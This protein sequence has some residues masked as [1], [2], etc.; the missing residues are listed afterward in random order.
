MGS[1]GIDEH[2]AKLLW[3]LQHTLAFQGENSKHRTDID[4]NKLSLSSLHVCF[5]VV[6]V[7]AL[8]HISNEDHGERVRKI[9]T[10]A[11]SVKKPKR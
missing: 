1:R 4:T 6:L 11:G 9:A 5:S 3:I 10:V 2:P 8:P 7:N